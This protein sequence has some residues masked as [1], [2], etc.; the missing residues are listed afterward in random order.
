MH[1]YAL[2]FAQNFGCDIANVT[3]FMHE[4]FTRSILCCYPWSKEA[5]DMQYPLIDLKKLSLKFP[6]HCC[7]S[8]LF[9]S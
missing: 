9:L 5:V 1:R 8:A 4:V 6:S 2:F 7:E 3:L